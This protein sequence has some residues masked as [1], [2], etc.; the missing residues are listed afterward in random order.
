M[1]T[2][3]LQDSAV[4]EPRIDNLEDSFQEDIASQDLNDTVYFH[5]RS[6]LNESVVTGNDSVSP[7]DTFLENMSQWLA[8]DISAGLKYIY[9]QYKI[10]QSNVRD[11]NQ[12]EVEIEISQLLAQH[13]AK[14][15]GLITELE[16][17]FSDVHESLRY[18]EIINLASDDKENEQIKMNKLK[19]SIQEQVNDMQNLLSGYKTQ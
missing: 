16:T 11:S 1:P 13:K 15:V 14:L 8:N 17:R 3:S 18:F 19:K 7:I 6:Q 9:Q 12:H 2:I 4:K 5:M 10:E